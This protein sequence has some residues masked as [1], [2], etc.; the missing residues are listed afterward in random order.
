MNKNEIRFGNYFS[1]KDIVTG[2]YTGFGIFSETTLYRLNAGEDVG[3]YTPL[4]EEEI[5]KF[6]IEKTNEKAFSDQI[7][8]KFKEYNLY[9]SGG[10]F[11]KLTSTGSYNMLNQ[12][13]IRF[14]HEF[15]NF[16]ESITGEKLAHFSTEP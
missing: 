8:F 1:K 5:L 10:Y 4:T 6:D 3:I 12:R 13:H 7:L 14:V 2:K 15:Q 9:F 16:Y 11:L